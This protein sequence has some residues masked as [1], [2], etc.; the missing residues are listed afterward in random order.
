MATAKRRPRPAV[1]LFAGIIL[2]FGLFVFFSTYV[3]ASKYYSQT[4][5]LVLILLFLLLAGLTYT[6][7]S[8]FKGQSGN[9]VG[10]PIGPLRALVSRVE[11]MF[12]RTLGLA[13]SLAVADMLLTNYAIS[14]F[15]IQLERNP[16]VAELVSKGDFYTWF[17]Q[18]IAPLMIAG[19]LFALTRR[20]SL[21]SPMSFYILG[22]LGY[23]IFVIANNITVLISSIL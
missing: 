1:Q 18:Q 21:R 11:G 22:T 19:A 12:W 3:E 2:A 16:F 15:G 14:R 23:S 13:T 4:A 7:S 10:P 5:T 8:I 6:S 20:R 17:G 9:S